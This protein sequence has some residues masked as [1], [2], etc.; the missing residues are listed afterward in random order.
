MNKSEQLRLSIPKIIRN[1]ADRD[2]LLMNLEFFLGDYEKVI[3]KSKK[4]LTK[5]LNQI[6]RSRILTDLAWFGRK[7]NMEK[8]WKLQ[9]Q[10]CK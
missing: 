2:Y 6:E 3:K 10:L 9:A 5:K 4:R 8:L 7:I 1:Q